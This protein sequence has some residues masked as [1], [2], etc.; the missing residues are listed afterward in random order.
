MKLIKILSNIKQLSK[1]SKLLLFPSPY[2]NY[3]LYSLRNNNIVRQQ[4]QKNYFSVFHKVSKIKNRNSKFI[5]TKILSNIQPNKQ[6]QDQMIYQQKLLTEIKK[7]NKIENQIKYQIN[8]KFNETE[9]K[10]CNLLREVIESLKKR[11]PELPP[12]ELRIVGGWVRDKL[13]GY[14][15]ND[16]D[17]AIDRMMGCEFCNEINDYLTL[18]G[19]DLNRIHKIE[20]NPDKSKHLETAT[21]KLFE[22]EIDFV[23][24]RNEEYNENSRI[25]NK[26]TF[27][28]PEQDAYRRDATINALFYNINTDEIEDFTKKGIPDLIQGIIRTPLPAYETFRDDPLRI[29]RLIRF[30]SRFHFEI[31]DDILNSIKDKRIKEALK[32]KISRERFGQ[33]L[34]KMIKGPDPVLSIELICKLGLYEII[35]CPIPDYT[36]IRN[37]GNSNDVIKFA[38]ILNWILSTLIGDDDIDNNHHLNDNNSSSSSIDNNSNNNNSSNNHINSNIDYINNN[39]LHLYPKI[40]SQ[41]SQDIRILYLTSLLI[42]YKNVQY[43]DIKAQQHHEKSEKNE[44]KR[45]KTE[46]MSAIGYVTRASVKLST[47]DG[48]M[49]ER[50]I[51]NINNIMN[52]VGKN[53]EII[54]DRKSMGLFIRELGSKWINSIIITLAYELMPEFYNIQKELWDKPNEIIRKYNNFIARIYDLGLQECYEEKSILNGDEVI[55][56]LNIKPG[57]IMKQIL[58]SVI[59]WQLENPNGNKEQCKKYIKDLPLPSTDGQIN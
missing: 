35:F 12:V 25:P 15:C 20:S 19:V 29:I 14:E 59:E 11:D 47:A 26:V 34:D 37:F 8:I 54:L 2:P 46:D 33:E 6:N 9:S 27:G 16:M 23:N 42:P 36:Q 17:I 43:Q 22:N 52:E 3:S 41:S 44:K 24:L 30:A 18:Q 5:S 56:L 10:I 13:L 28:T 1:R 53:E 51:N 40:P 58:A 57:K 21:T 31:V 4:Q 39:L 55:K 50:L 32:S 45:R 49:V 48:D 7:N 38:K